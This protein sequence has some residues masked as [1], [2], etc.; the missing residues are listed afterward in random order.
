MLGDLQAR[1]KDL[2]GVVHGDDFVFGGND[3]DL[4]WVAKILAPKFV[5]KVRAVLGPEDE[6]QKDEVLLGRLGN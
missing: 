1:K 4:K 2:L 6:D 3:E 5:I